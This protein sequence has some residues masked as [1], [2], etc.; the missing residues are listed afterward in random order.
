MEMPSPCTAPELIESQERN[1]RKIPISLVDP[2]FGEQT[3]QARGYLFGS[4][5]EPERTAENNF[6]RPNASAKVRKHWTLAE[7]LM[8]FLAILIR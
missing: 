3:A 7:S 2:D 8:N 5:P 4:S 1:W 6:D